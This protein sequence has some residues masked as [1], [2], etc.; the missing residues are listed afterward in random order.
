MN[1]SR[2]NMQRAIDFSAVANPE[3]I[4]HAIRALLKRRRKPMREREICKWFRGT[5]NSFVCVSLAILAGRG[6]IRQRELARGATEYWR[7]Q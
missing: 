1:C 2:Q 5:P 7:E 3:A 6:E 4:H